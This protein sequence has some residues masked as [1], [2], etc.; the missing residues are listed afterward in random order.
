MHWSPR[1]PSKLTLV[2]AFTVKKAKYNG[3]PYSPGPHEAEEF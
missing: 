3:L 1:T 2:L